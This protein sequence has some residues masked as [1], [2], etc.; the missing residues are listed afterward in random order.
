MED[1]LESESSEDEA[2]P[3]SMTRVTSIEIIDEVCVNPPE[4]LNARKKW[5]KSEFDKRAYLD[6]RFFVVDYDKSDVDENGI[7]ETVRQLCPSNPEKRIR[8][9]YTT[10]SNFITHLKVR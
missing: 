6:G 5:L 2:M 10:S 3:E 9:S 7:V 8:G 1:R 4:N